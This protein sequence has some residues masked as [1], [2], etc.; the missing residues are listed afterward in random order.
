VKD[1]L[2][3]AA[4]KLA[5]ARFVTALTGAGIS[6]ESGIPIFRGAGGLWNNYR[7]EDL[8]TPQAFAVNPRL[9][10]EW[11]GWRQGLIAKAEPNAGHGALA[12]LERRLPGFTL[13]TQNVDGLH[14]RAGSEDPIE[15][16]GSIWKVRCTG[17]DH[18]RT[19]SEPVEEPPHCED[20]GALER[21]GVVWFG[22]SLPEDA[23]E[24]A[25][26]A[27]ARAEVLLVVGT[28]GMV[29]PAASLVEV[30]RSRGAFVIEVNPEASPGGRNRIALAGPA[31]TILP[32]LV[33]A[34]AS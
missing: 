8:A 9:V 27:A 32:A 6:A 11:Y 5:A 22:E 17:C 12:A 13:V 18:E 21:P 20:C 16:H 2:D 15:L 23:F 10:W 25:L 14:S 33:Q 28:S 26:S 7:P 24:A 4:R 30:G 34:S 19:L 31:G 1:L 3:E 29:Q